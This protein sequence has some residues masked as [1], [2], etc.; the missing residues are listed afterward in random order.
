MSIL[1]EVNSVDNFT[2]GLIIKRLVHVL[3]LLSSSI[4]LVCELCYEDQY[5]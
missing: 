5:L 1:F 4:H 2:E 3:L